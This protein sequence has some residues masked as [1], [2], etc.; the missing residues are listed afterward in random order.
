[1]KSSRVIFLIWFV[2]LA[3]CV[4]LATDAL[5]WLRGD[6]PWIPLL[7]RWRWPYGHPRWRWLIPCAL[8]LALYTGGALVLL[9]RRL[10]PRYPVRLVLWAFVGAALLW[11][12]LLTLE[13]PPI[14]LLFTRSAS[15]VTGGY[16]YAA[17]LVTD[18]DSTLRHW[19]PFVDDYL[20]TV[21]LDPPGGVALSPPGLLAVYEANGTLLDGVPLLADHAAALIRPQQCQNLAMMA[22]TNADLGSAW[23][24]MWMPLWAA[25]GIAPLYRLGTLIF[26]RARARL[27]VAVWPLV[28]GLAIFI[29][30]FNVF[31]PLITLVVLVNLWRGLLHNRPRWIAVSGFT[32]SVGILLNLSL[33]PLGL[34]AGLTILGWHVLADTGLTPSA[35]TGRGR[36]EPSVRQTRPGRVTDPPLQKN[37]PHAHDSYDPVR[38]MGTRRAARDLALFGAGCASSWLIYALLAGLSLGDLLSGFDRH[39]DLYRPYL[40]WLL[41]HPYDM[42][43]FVGLPVAAFAL[44]RMMRLRRVRGGNITPGDLFTGAAALTLVILVLSGTARGETGRVWLYFAP[45]WILL[46]VDVLADFGPREWAGFLAL[47]AVCVL[48]M[49]GFW[50]ANFTGLTEP[51][52][53]AEA[54]SAPTFPAH[55]RFT[56][57][58]D[59][60]TLIGLDL[61]AASTG[62][63]LRLHW[64]AET[65]VMRPYVLNLLSIPPDGSPP[66]SLTWNPEGWNYPPACWTPGRT[67]VDTVPL[68]LGDKLM[69]GNWLFSL[70]IVDAF[71]GESMAVTLPGGEVSTQFG[72]GPVEIPAE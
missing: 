50:R 51:P 65:R 49:A 18:L 40:P 9:R 53:P 2:T 64:R 31:F 43:I 68:S 27:A 67:F 19:S 12:L 36:C 71:T 72:I 47:Q 35:W 20:A 54:A 38:W 57:G 63:T 14:F 8:A 6:V 56:R 39:A 13:G 32:L 45:V 61:D 16:Q 11:T 34:L 44:W 30:R 46:A 59:A 52:Q 15:P 41:L 24:Q 37:Q 7:G 22:W 69:P 21:Q 55:A 62:I 4:L 58:D 66:E 48:S 25:L 23:F 5:P 1:V 28:P 17:A 3:F 70:S 10:N 33:V 42:F 60:V 29:P 26:D